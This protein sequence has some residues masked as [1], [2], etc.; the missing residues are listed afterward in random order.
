MKQLLTTV[1]L[2]LYISIKVQQTENIILITTDGYRWQE[3]FK[4]MDSAIANNPKFNQ[5][6]SSYIFENYWSNEEN[7]RRKKLLPFFWNTIVDHG[8]IYGNRRFGHK[9]N[10]A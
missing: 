10:N 9:V 6:D 4:G 1:L 8:Q 3:L 2:V 5:G 7:E